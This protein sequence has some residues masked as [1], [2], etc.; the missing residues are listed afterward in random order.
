MNHLGF[1]SFAR[2]N[3]QALAIVD[4]EG[5]ATTRGELHAECN[6]LVH[7]LRALGLARGDAFAVLSPNSREF[8][9]LYL[10]AAQGGFYMVPLNWHLAAP[11]AAYILQDSGAKAF[12]ASARIGA[13]ATA[14]ADE[15]GLAPAGRI[16]IGAIPGFRD[17][18][19][20]L[21]GASSEEPSERRAGTVMNYTS[22]TTGRPKGVRR[23]LPDIDPDTAATMAAL[24]LGIFGIQPESGN[25]HLVGSPL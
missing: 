14:A 11:E 21:A 24:F 13:V 15:A 4:P 19:D 8:L 9:A 10:A 5:R 1:W 2:N 12:F 22:G 6:R 16:A 20:L 18:A 3:P 7:A 23:A 17:W 25:V